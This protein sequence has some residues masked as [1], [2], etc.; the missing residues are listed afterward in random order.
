MEGAWP[1][2]H[3]QASLG[4]DQL[5]DLLCVLLMGRLLQASLGRD[6]LTG[7]HCVS[8]VGDSRGAHGEGGLP[9]QVG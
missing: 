3:V 2:G 4:R 8:L 9:P 5:A 6:Q 7:L 1:R